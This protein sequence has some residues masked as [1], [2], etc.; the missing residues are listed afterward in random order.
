MMKLA[1]VAALALGGLLIS[2]GAAGAQDVASFYRTQT[3]KLV[4]GSP[5]GGSYDLYARAIARHLGEHLPGQPAVIVQNMPGGGGYAAANNLFNTAPRDGT[6]IAT[7]SRSVPMQP[8]IDD[9][10]VRFDP[11]KFAWIGSPSDEVGVTLSSSASPI[12]SIEDVRRRGMV[13]A[14]TGPGTDSN[15]YAR[16]IA[17]ALSLDIKIVTGYTGAADMLLAVQRG[18]AEG[19]AGISWSSLWPAHKELIE[20][21]KV[22]ILL[23]LGLRGGSDAALKGI[24]LAVD[25]V[26]TPAERAV[27]EVIFARQ[28]MAYPF[29]APPDVPPE[30]LAALRSAFAAT[31]ADPAFIAEA[32][33]AGMS[34]NPVSHEEMTRIIERVY[35]SPPELVA[36]VKAAMGLDAAK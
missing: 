16:V 33:M 29:A 10:G 22:N 30:R 28:T 11:R 15:V 8:L 5:P 36:Q 31:M 35:A 14:A 1:H 12:K 13:V 20:N 18:E 9:T 17:R 32:S 21:H 24:P 27:L 7:F 4:V 23:Q 2:P 25:L 19:S 6:V 3:I 34:V 26:K